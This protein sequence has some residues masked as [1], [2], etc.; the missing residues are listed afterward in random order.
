MLLEALISILIFSLGILGIVK[1]QS[2]SVQQSS[3]ANYRVLASMLAND[4]I[5]QMWV[6]DKATLESDFESGAKYTAWAQKVTASGLPGISSEVNQ[7]SI[8]ITSVAA[9]STA[10]GSTP[11]YQALV[12]VPWK[13]P[14]DSAV[15]KY[16]VVAQIK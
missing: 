3:T 1:L 4:V 2:V 16:I 8:A 14:S 13:S 11:S 6:S 10:P 7:P 9:G 5:S 15:Q 12:T